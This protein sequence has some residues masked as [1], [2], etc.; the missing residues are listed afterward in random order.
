MRILKEGINTGWSAYN[1]N[2]EILAYPF[3]QKALL[4]SFFAVFICAVAG[5]LVVVNRSVF[6]TGG[7]AH[8]SYGGIGLALFLG[9]SPVAGALILATFMGVVLGLVRRKNEG[10]ADA[11]V[12]AFWAAGM[13]GGI[14]L[15][16]INPGYKSDFLSYLFG[17]ILVVSKTDLFLIG[18]FAFLL[19]GLALKYYRVILAISAD[20]DYAATLGI[21]VRWINLVMLVLLCLSVIMLMRVAGLI[22]VM[23]LLS[24]PAA[25]ARAHTGKLSS[26][27]VLSGVIAALAVF[28]GLGI[29]VFTNLTPGA[30]IVAVL[31][32]IYL[33]N[34]LFTR[35]V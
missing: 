4:A 20:Q 11:L 21:N 17:S 34:I 5:T 2:M 10:K 26:A 29:S 14:L 12:S 33:C 6:I 3:M 25:V 15:S 30:V 7:V 22:M 35:T 9:F 13:A 32:L 16:D 8:A 23:A 28:G 1:P 27:M 31:A 18:L 19:V 24:I